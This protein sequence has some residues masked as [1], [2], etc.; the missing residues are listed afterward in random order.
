MSFCLKIF[1]QYTFNQVKTERSEITGDNNWFIYGHFI[2]RIQ[3]SR[4]EQKRCVA[5]REEMWFE[6]WIDRRSDGDY[7]GIRWNR[8]RTAGSWSKIAWNGCDSWRGQCDG[9]KGCFAYQ[10]FNCKGWRRIGEK[11]RFRRRRILRED[12][13]NEC[14][15][16]KHETSETRK[17]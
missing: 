14:E 16:R 5:S 2:K 15:Q 4:C 9:L 17:V 1:Q 11:V 7:R 6:G 10:L 3:Q 8:R 13:L 12:Q